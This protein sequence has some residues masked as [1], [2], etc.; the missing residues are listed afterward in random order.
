[1]GCS[2]ARRRNGNG[3]DDII[4]ISRAVANSLPEPGGLYM[5]QKAQEALKKLGKMSDSDLVEAAT[6]SQFEEVRDAALT[7]ISH[8]PGALA[9]VLNI[10]P[11]SDTSQKAEQLK[12]EAEKKKRE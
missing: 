4:P 11:Y 10:C 12:M 5:A 3:K 7:R 9:S 8:D 2:S 6:Y 1:M